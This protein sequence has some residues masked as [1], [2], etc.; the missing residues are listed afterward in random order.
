M[1]T[2]AQPTPPSAGD[3]RPAGSVEQ[4]T[5]EPG[6]EARVAEFWSRNRNAILLG[7][8]VVL[9]VIVGRSGWE[10]LQERRARDQAAAYAAASDQ[11]QLKAFASEHDGSALGGVAS[12]RLADEAYAEGRYADALN[13]YQ[14]AQRSLDGTPL[15]GRVRLGVA[16]STLKQGQTEAGKAALQEL[17]NDVGG[18]K[19]LRAEAAYHLASLALAEGNTAEVTRL[20]E[21]IT[22]IE[23]TGMWAQRAMML[24]PVAPAPSPASEEEP[25]INFPGARP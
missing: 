14:R 8:L 16:M 15:Q 23:P 2:P 17:A 4:T 11:A 1:S 6:F 24:Q 20:V 18:T 3:H 13:D 25:A 7:C 10:W 5:F 19:P 22:A 12:L 21:L 9:L